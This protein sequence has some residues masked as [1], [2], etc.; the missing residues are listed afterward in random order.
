MYSGSLVIGKAS[1]IEI[2]PTPPQGGQKVQNLALLSTSL[3]NHST[4]S[5]PCL[6]MQQG[7]QT[8]KQKCTAVIID[9]CS[10]QVG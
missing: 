2:S 5:R 8:L 4:F 10:H 6:K 9:L 7:I 1:T 3:A